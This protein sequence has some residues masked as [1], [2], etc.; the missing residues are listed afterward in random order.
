[1]NDELLIMCR[2]HPFGKLPGAHYK[3]AIRGQWK[4]HYDPIS[5]GPEK[6]N[7]PLLNDKVN[8]LQ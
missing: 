7:I 5:L 2:R 6:E 1:M 4:G 8:I 3:V